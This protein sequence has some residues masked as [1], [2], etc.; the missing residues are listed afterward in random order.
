MQFDVNK[1]LHDSADASHRTIYLYNIIWVDKYLRSRTSML[2]AILLLVALV[3]AFRDT[4]AA[5][6][7]VRAELALGSFAVRAWKDNAFRS[8]CSTIVAHRVAA[9]GTCIF[10]HLHQQSESDQIVTDMP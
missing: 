4:N 10:A 5:V 9:C 7:T 6:L 2:L 8:L 1:R 3:G